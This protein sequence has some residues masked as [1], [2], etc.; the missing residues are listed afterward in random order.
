MQENI[1]SRLFKFFWRGDSVRD[2][3]IFHNKHLTYT[4]LPFWL[5]FG[6]MKMKELL[7][8]LRIWRGR[9]FSSWHH[10][11]PLFYCLTATSAIK[12]N[13]YRNSWQNL[14]QLFSFEI[15]MICTKFPFYFIQV[16]NNSS[17]ETEFVILLRFNYV[18][19]TSGPLLC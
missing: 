12:K 7:L 6:Q 3:N 2:E 11:E 14:N 17:F 8:T 4:Q 18:T 5:R 10:E 15:F 16:H 13:I 19:V 9:S 1:K